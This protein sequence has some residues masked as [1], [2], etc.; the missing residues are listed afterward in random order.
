M[1]P[2]PPSET[3]DSKLQT[4]ETASVAG[5]GRGAPAWLIAL[6]VLALGGVAA[7][8]AYGWDY[9]STPLVE[10]PRH[11]LYWTLKPGGT[12]GR[13]YG[14]AGATLMLVMLSYSMRKRV[15]A[16]SGVGKLRSWLDFHIWCGVVGPLLIVLHSSF[17]VTGLVALSFWSMVLVAASGVLGRYLYLQIPRRRSGDEMSLAEVDRYRAEL[18]ESLVSEHGLAPEA[19]ERIDALAARSVDAGAGLLRTL[20]TLPTGAARLRWRVASLVR[21]LAPSHRRRLRQLIEERALLA[22]RI[23]L[24][25]RLQELFH[26]WHVLHKPFAIVMYLFAAVHIVVAT[27]TGYGFS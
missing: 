9:Y 2:L 24:W 8:A 18:N 25:Q 27:V 11:P 13:A 19:L 12:L 4:T 6:Y 10:R 15:K 5:A 1:S 3:S 23:V 26:Y 7:L 14:I 20:I 22:R 21:S 17:K 16:L